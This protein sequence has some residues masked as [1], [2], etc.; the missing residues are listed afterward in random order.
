MWGYQEIY[1]RTYYQNKFGRRASWKRKNVS[2]QVKYDLG[3]GKELSAINPSDESISY[4]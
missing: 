3:S 2:Q 4:I 1:C